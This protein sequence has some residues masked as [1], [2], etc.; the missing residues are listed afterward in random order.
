[1]VAVLFARL[2]APIRSVMLVC[3]EHQGILRGAGGQSVGAAV[4]FVGFYLVSLP[5]AFSLAYAA[6]LGLHGM[7][8][9]MLIGY[10]VVGTL[11][12]TAI[13]RLKWQ[14][15]ADHAV[16]IASE[17]EPIL[18]NDSKDGSVF[19]EQVELHVLEPA[20]SHCVS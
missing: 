2:H 12:L 8:F 19:G 11:Y 1:M 20:A 15:I 18:L 13:L 10:A 3:C 9:G 7:W 4:S 14:H 6:H 5:C 17:S 16:L